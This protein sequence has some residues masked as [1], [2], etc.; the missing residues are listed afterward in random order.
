M[1]VWTEYMKYRAE[2]RGFDVSLVENIL[3]FSKERYHDTCTGRKVVVGRHGG[4]LVMIPYEQSGDDIVPVTI[5][6]TTRQQINFRLKTG[7]FCND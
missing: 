4:L 1:I 6:A 2:L 5:H 7:R 3:R